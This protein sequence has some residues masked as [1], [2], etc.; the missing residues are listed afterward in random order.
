MTT[1]KC[2]NYKE[3]QKDKNTKNRLKKMQND[4]KDITFCSINEN[5]LKLKCHYSVSCEL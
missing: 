5:V 4:Y 2:K 3:T 1:K